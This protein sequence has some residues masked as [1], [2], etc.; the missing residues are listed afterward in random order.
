MFGSWQARVSQNVCTQAVAIELKEDSLANLCPKC[1]RWQCAL[2]PCLPGFLLTALAVRPSL[3][4]H[5][6]DKNTHVKDV[7]VHQNLKSKSGEEKKCCANWVDDEKIEYC[8]ATTS[9][10]EWGQN[11]DDRDYSTV[12]DD[13]CKAASDCA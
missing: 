13:H 5:H 11:S 1:I 2:L 6:H 3:E 10:L 12:D 9:C 8:W 7:H 4:H